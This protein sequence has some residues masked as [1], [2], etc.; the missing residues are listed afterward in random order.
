MLPFTRG[1]TRSSSVEAK[2]NLSKSNS[3]TLVMDSIFS[4]SASDSVGQSVS[5]SVSHSVIQSVSQSV[6]SL[7]IE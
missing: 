4:R 1:I 6:V 2:E 3:L 5:Q 7:F